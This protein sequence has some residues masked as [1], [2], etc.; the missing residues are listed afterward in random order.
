MVEEQSAN[1]HEAAPMKGLQMLQRQFDLGQD[2]GFSALQ[3]DLVARHVRTT[4]VY[5][6]VVNWASQ[7]I[8]GSFTTC[9]GEALVCYTGTTYRP[10]PSAR[11]CLTACIQEVHADRSAGVSC[12][13]FAAHR[14]YEET[15]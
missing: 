3:N 9:R 10:V 14:C 2:L 8:N 15:I 11:C 13:Y 12:L 7:S 5:T 4:M 1:G 6:H